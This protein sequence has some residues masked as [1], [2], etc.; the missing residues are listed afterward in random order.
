MHSQG[1]HVLM[2]NLNAIVTGSERTASS[3]GI[4]SEWTREDTGESGRVLFLDAGLTF[5]L[6][7]LMKV[8]TESSVMTCCIVK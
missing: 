6:A 2:V 5:P 1:C 4:I 7:R 8:I 3:D